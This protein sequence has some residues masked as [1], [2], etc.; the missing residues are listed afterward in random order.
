[1]FHSFCFVWRFNPGVCHADQIS[2]QWQA[3]AAFIEIT[4]KEVFE[5]RRDFIRQLAVGTIAGGSL[6]EMAS[7]EAFAQTPAAQKLAANLIRH[8]RW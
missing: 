4:P 6:L 8:T 1:V 5:S 3:F 7:R 2:S